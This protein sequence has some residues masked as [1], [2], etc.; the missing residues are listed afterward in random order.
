MD[1]GLQETPTPCQIVDFI[2]N[3]KNIAEMSGLLIFTFNKSK[4]IQRLKQQL[5]QK[6][7][8]QTPQNCCLYCIFLQLLQVWFQV[9]TATGE[10]HV[11][12]KE[13]A[14]VRR[15]GLQGGEFFNLWLRGVRPTRAQYISGS[16]LNRASCLTLPNFQK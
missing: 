10:G 9:T 16:G 13:T 4:W 1:L 5:G 11:P 8:P 14:S 3:K 7:D 15:P 12:P 2:Y 6:R